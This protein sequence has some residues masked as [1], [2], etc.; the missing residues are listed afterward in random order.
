[1]GIPSLPTGPSTSRSA[2]PAS[3][4]DTAPETT[5]IQRTRTEDPEQLDQAKADAARAASVTA[6]DETNKR[7]I[8]E[9]GPA[10]TDMQNAE[11]DHGPEASVY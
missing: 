8:E 5:Q 11:R 9:Y 7:L 3:A 4:S 1:M 10:E 6:R 2:S